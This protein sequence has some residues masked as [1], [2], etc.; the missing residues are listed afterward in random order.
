MRLKSRV[1][2]HPPHSRRHEDI[3]FYLDRIIGA[4]VSS[5]A[6]KEAQS[7]R[8]KVTTTTGNTLN[9]L[10]ATN[11]EGDAQRF[12]AYTNDMSL[13][14][15]DQTPRGLEYSIY[16]YMAEQLVGQ[17]HVDVQVFQTPHE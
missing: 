15:V 2:V 10:I 1:P 5:V 6:R 3:R 16:V 8:L 13:Y 12:V 9:V 4:A 7:A 17:N 14:V 11:G